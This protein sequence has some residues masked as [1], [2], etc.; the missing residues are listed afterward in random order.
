MLAIFLTHLVDGHDVGMLQPRARPGLRIKSL[1]LLRPREA[2]GPNQLQRDVAAESTVSSPPDDS[3]SAPCDFLDQVIISQPPHAAMFCGF[4]GV[5]P[6]AERQ[7][8]QTRRAISTGCVGR[9]GSAASLAISFRR[10][11][12]YPC[13]YTKV[14]GGYILPLGQSAATNAVM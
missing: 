10:A 11:D 4:R 12:Q 5:L 3:H 14:A 7:S 1:D 9:E 13:S 6:D 8:Q 2:A